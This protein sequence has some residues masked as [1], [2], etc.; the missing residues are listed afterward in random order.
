MNL[1]QGFKGSKR[2]SYVTLLVKNIPRRGE[3]MSKVSGAQQGSQN[4]EKGAEQR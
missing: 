1:K 4:W 2:I 3:R